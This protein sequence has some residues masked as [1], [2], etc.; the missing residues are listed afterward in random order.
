M[1]QPFK[2]ISDT[3]VKQRHAYFSKSTASS[4]DENNLSLGNGSDLLLLGIDGG[5][6][7]AM[8]TGRE[9]EGFR[10]IIGM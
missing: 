3:R 7:I 5:V 8:Y 6:H 9:L 4:S 10:P 2:L 1:S